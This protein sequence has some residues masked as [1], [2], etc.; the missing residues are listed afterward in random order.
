MP[1][2]GCG[3]RWVVKRRMIARKKRE[4]RPNAVQELQE[5]RQRMF[6]GLEDTVTP[7]LRKKAM[8]EIKVQT[9]SQLMEFRQRTQDSQIRFPQ[10]AGFS[11]EITH[12][13]MP[14]EFLAIK[15][16]KEIRTRQYPRLGR[17]RPRSRAS[18]RGAY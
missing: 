12:S 5:L 14:S 10:Q 13:H 16:T 9:R 7:E 2:K 1:L 18:R 11:H 8:T 3:Y 15:D 17:L 6:G 4:H